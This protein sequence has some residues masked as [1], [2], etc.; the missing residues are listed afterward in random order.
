MDQSQIHGLGLFAQRSLLRNEMIIEYAG[1]LI[2]SVL[3]DKREAYY[4]AHHIGT[5]MF[6]IDDELVVDATMKGNSARFIN[7]CCEVR[8]CLALFVPGFFLPF[9]VFALAQLLLPHHHGRG[10]QENHHLRAARHCRGR[11]VYLRLQG[12][13]VLLA[14]CGRKNLMSLPPWL[15]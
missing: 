5:Y 10:R 2:R 3:C 6:R 9:T 7:H 8:T 15:W 4:D 14:A 1:E 11:G 13:G 12:A